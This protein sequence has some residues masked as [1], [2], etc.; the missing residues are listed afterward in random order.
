MW[1]WY[2]SIGRLYTYRWVDL[3]LYSIKICSNSLYL[4][5]EVSIYGI[6]LRFTIATPRDI[7]TAIRFLT[8]LIF[9]FIPH[10]IFDWREWKVL[11]REESTITNNTRSF[12]ICNET[13]GSCVKGVQRWGSR[14]SQSRQS[15][16]RIRFVWFRLSR[17]IGQRFYVRT[18]NYAMAFLPGIFPRLSASVRFPWPLRLEATSPRQEQQR[19]CA[20]NASDLV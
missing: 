16:R 12:N 17:R 8:D 9:I 13:Q 7:T 5:T 3:A 2:G 4:T 1:N 6:H 19:P 10:S 20:A 11:S 14:G 18:E 15:R